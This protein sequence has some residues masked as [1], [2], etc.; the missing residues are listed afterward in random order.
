[1]TAP[2]VLDVSRLLSRASRRVPTGIDRVEHAYAEGLLQ[3]ARDRL[4]YAAVSPL[5]RFCHLPTATTRHF[6]QQTGLEWQHAM[7]VRADDLPSPPGD[8]R[9]LARRLQTALMLPHRGPRFLKRQTPNGQRPTYLLVS[10]HHLHQPKAI[11]AAK[12]R[13]DAAFV[14]F[15]HDLIP[16]EF[17]EY[18]RPNEAAKHRLRIETA[19]QY[20]DAFVVNSVSTRDALLPFMRAAGREVPLI[21]APLGVH[22]SARPPTADPSSEP[23]YF[24]YIGTIEPRKNHLLLFQIWRRLALEMG[25]RCPRLVL[26]GQRGW[27]NEMVLDVIE[28]SEI[29]RDRIVEYNALPDEKVHALIAGARAVLLPSFAEGYGLPVAEAL[30]AGTPVLCSDLPALREVGGATPEY[31]DPLDGLSWLEAIRDYASPASVRRAD[32][33]GRLAQWSPPSWQAHLDAVLHLIDD[34]AGVAA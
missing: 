8:L 26:V 27:E 3:T 31:L 28:R 1:M 11:Q 5:G 9:S 32:Q 23:P 24:L 16:I 25:E 12:D 29:L 20:A 2:I 13:L 6:V 7:R 19:T 22:E 21:V 33:L 18:N 17:P 15:I 10:H 30:S 14:C 4:R 34:V